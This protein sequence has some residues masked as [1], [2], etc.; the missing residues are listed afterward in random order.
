ML[1]LRRQR[2]P[3]LLAH[4]Q[5]VHL[6]N[7]LCRPLA[8]LHL[9]LSLGLH[10]HPLRPGRQ[11]PRRA[12]GTLHNKLD[13]SSRPLRSLHHRPRLQ[14]HQA[15][16]PRRPGNQL[17]ANLQPDRHRHHSEGLRPHACSPQPSPILGLSLQRLRPVRSLRPPL[18]SPDDHWTSRPVDRCG[19]RRADH[20]DCPSC[21]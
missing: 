8:V 3:L 5:A 13:P 19:Y 12:R 9:H 14:R 18:C 15:A 7:N 2:P 16:H 11:H 10:V 4:G 20:G 6:P 21:G 1:H 17:P